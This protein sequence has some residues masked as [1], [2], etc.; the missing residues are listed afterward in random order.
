MAISANVSGGRELF[1]AALSD[2]QRLERPNLLALAEALHGAGVASGRVAGV[3]CVGE[4]IITAGQEVALVAELRR[5]EGRWTGNR[6]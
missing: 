3:R 6:P 5:L 2:G 4:P 1:F